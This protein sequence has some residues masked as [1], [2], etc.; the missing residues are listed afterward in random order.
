MRPTQTVRV[1]Q[2]TLCAT[3]TARVVYNLRAMDWHDQLVTAQED[4]AEAGG[5]PRRSVDLCVDLLRSEVVSLDSWQRD[6]VAYDVPEDD[7]LDEMLASISID[8]LVA[9]AMAVLTGGQRTEK[10]RES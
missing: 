5:A 8:E 2:G 4:D 1:E 3:L 9:L 6:G 7:W 10:K